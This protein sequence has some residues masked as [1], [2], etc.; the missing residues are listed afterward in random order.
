[1]YVQKYSIV[2]YFI[3]P[4]FGSNKI[5]SVFSIIDGHIWLTFKLRAKP[6]Q[7]WA[8]FGFSNL[9][10]LGQTEKQTQSPRISQWQVTS[11]FLPRITWMLS[12]HLKKIT[13]NLLE[14]EKAKLFL[15]LYDLFE[16]QKCPHQLNLILALNHPTILGW[17]L[18]FHPN[19]ISVIG[20]F[21]VLHSNSGFLQ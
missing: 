12:I 18:L 21:Y 1:M 3:Q 11:L 4:A 13:K 5:L 9:R 10:A 14:K 19:L 2:K 16:V 6:N 8:V 17:I 7:A 20:F 15:N